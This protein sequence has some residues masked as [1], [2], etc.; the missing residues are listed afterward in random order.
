MKVVVTEAYTSSFPNPIRLEK[1]EVVQVEKRETE[2]AGWI[3]TTTGD[4]NSGW[5]PEPLLDISGASAVVKEDYNARELNTQVGEELMVY[6]ELNEWYWV[7]NTAGEY[8][9]VP[10]RS[11]AEAE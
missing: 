3:W 2:F 7:S 4:G 1:G 5:T 9:W 11:V 6:H 8:G 10:V